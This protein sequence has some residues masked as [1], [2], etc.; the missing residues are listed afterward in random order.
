MP[1]IAKPRPVSCGFLLIWFNAI[2]D[3]TKP[4]VETSGPQ[5]KKPSK[6]SVNPAVAIVLLFDCGIAAAYCGCD[7]GTPSVG[8]TLVVVPNT[9]A[10]SGNAD[11]GFHSA[12]P[13]AC[14]NVCRLARPSEIHCSTCS[15]VI[16]P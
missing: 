16:G 12:L 15:R 7:C 1:A 13:S 4:I 8:G 2:M 10:N 3:S 6:L 9:P 11:N 5:Q 14:A